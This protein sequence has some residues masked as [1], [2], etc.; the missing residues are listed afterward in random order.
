M[1]NIKYKIFLFDFDGVIIDSN[2]VREYGFKI[3]LN[4]Y[5]DNKIQKLL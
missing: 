2:N 3:V 4:K 1:L 5:P